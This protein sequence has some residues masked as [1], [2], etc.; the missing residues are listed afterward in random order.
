MHLATD[1]NKQTKEITLVYTCPWCTAG[2]EIRLNLDEG[3]CLFHVSFLV[4]LFMA[5]ND[6]PS[7]FF[8]YRVA[9]D[10]IHFVTSVP[11]GMR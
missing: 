9:S 7:R 2:E 8:L 1:K 6:Y 3:S 4:Q 10:A 11:W 5:G